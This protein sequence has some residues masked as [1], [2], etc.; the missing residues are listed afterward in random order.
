MVRCSSCYASEDNCGERIRGRSGTRRVST[1]KDVHERLFLLS[2]RR[3]CTCQAP[4]H[5]EEDDSDDI[6]CTFIPAVN[7]THEALLFRW[8]EGI[9]VF[10]RLYGNALFLQRRRQQLYGSVT[11][12]RG[13]GVRP[14]PKAWSFSSSSVEQLRSA[15]PK[16]ICGSCD[17]VLR[18]NGTKV[19]SPLCLQGSEKREWFKPATMR[20][21][22]T[23]L[24]M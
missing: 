4:L 14:T 7:H 17:N 24:L 21:R 5:V 8:T 1:Q 10:E 11:H 3:R 18:K 16:A 12:E 20:A 2:Q 19:M 13:N 22:R 9:S 15:A 6:N 23:P